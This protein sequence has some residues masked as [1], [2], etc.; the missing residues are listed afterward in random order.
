M[1]L[2]QLLSRTMV[3]FSLLMMGACSH[4]QFYRARSVA[5]DEHVAGKFTH[6]SEKLETAG[7]QLT[8]WSNVDALEAEYAMMRHA[9]PTGLTVRIFRATRS[10]DGRTSLVCE[11]R[12]TDKHRGQ[13][14][15]DNI[16]AWLNEYGT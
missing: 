10:S 6:L 13:H 4:G 1:R 3:I 11:V 7:Y 8:D 5:V 2:T 16:Y 9:K 14:T 15:L 12:D